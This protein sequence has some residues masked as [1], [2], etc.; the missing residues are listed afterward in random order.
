MFFSTKNE[1]AKQTGQPTAMDSR[2]IKALEGYLQKVSG[3]D[4]S[5]AVPQVSSPQLQGLARELMAFVKEQQRSYIDLLMEINI[6]V[7]DESKSSESLNKVATEY[8]HI[9]Q[10]VNELMDV[11]DNMADAINGLA[12]SATETSKQTEVGKDAMSHTSSS[13]QS[14]AAETSQAQ[15]SLKGMNESVGQLHNSTAS[16]DNLVSVVNG[17]AEQTNLLALNAS[18]EAARAGE[19]GRGFSVVAEEV[20]KLAEQSKESV[21]E[22]S[23]QLSQI[24]TGADGIAK[25]FEQMDRSFQSNVTAVGEAQTHTSRLVDVFDGIG[26]AIKDLAPMAEEQSASFEEMNATLRGAMDNVHKLSSYTQEC[27]REVY[28]VLKRCNTMRMKA[29]SLNL[30]F[31]EK[32]IISLAKTDHLIWKTRIEQMLWG[33]IELKAADVADASICRLGKWYYSSGKQKYG[34]LPEFSQL[35]RAHDQFHKICADAIDAYHQQKKE[36]VR[37]YL[38]EISALSQE[39]IQALDGLMEKV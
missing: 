18:I 4:F 6:S 9:L 10:T 26:K 1:P 8:E 12:G 27:N 37:E 21:G 38:L 22:I 30:P 34:S 14:V 5:A 29:G 25:E 20:R 36:K 28:D 39:V 2:D 32:E 16:I 35:G 17:I 13:V 19:H 3:G 24:R 23:D 7:M 11:V 31:T 33:N 15:Q